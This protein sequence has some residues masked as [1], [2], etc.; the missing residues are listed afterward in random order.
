[1]SEEGSG[2]RLVRNTLA[3]GTASV[4]GVLV[5]L[6]L[7]PFMILE[8]G[9]AAYGVFT[10]ALSLSFLGGYAAFTDLGVEAAT[11][12]FVAEARADGDAAGANRVAS[13]TLAFFGGLAI[14]LAPVVAVLSP[15]L[16]DLFSIEGDLRE[17][18]KWCF[19][20]VGAQ[21]LFEMPARTYFAVLEGA[22]RFEWFQACE[23]VRLV[24]QAVLFIAVLIGGLSVAWLGGALALSSLIVL[25][26]ARVLAHRVMPELDINPRTATRGELRRLLGYG[27]GLVILRLTGT[28]FRQMD[29][30]IIAVALGPRSVTIYEIANKIQAAAQM[31]QSVA[32]SALVPAAAFARARIEVLQDMFLRGSTYS[33]AVALPFAGAVAI[34]AEPLIRTWIDPEYTDAAS[35]TRLFSIYLVLASLLVVGVTMAT[36]LGHLR[37]FI[38]VNVPVILANLAISIALVGPMGIDGV[39]IGSVVPFAVAFPIQLRFLLRR[40]ELRVGQ[41]LRQALLPH[42][43]G[44]LMQA[45]TAMPLLALSEGADTVIEAGLIALVSIGLSIGTFLLVGLSR[46][47]RGVLFGIV[48]DALGISR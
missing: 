11:A 12:R 32:A 29:R 5:F 15:L 8:L 47:N 41:W 22:Q 1:M 28:M 43:P 34:F 26:V 48:R 4:F 13:T 42:L 19:A 35:V 30:V 10:L 33:L 31:V 40:F 27:G 37:F 46:E 24:S 7:T 20:L 17:E 45:A 16:V 2:A 39:V 3:N 21:L 18:A 23:M 6:V 25:I 9:A 14:L 38:L 44:A 36:A